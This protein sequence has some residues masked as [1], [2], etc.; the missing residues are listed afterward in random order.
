MVI[1]VVIIVVS[2]FTYTI[3]D[4]LHH[5]AFNHNVTQMQD[6]I[7]SFVD[8]DTIFVQILQ[9]HQA[10]QFTRTDQN[11]QT[12]YSKMNDEM[13]FIQQENLYPTNADQANDEE[14]ETIIANNSV[15]ISW[16]QLET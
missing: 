11:S 10:I 13:P 6:V 4:D 14:D 8:F 9:Y 12:Q 7:D 16:A 3:A 5:Q 1:I 2:I 15:H